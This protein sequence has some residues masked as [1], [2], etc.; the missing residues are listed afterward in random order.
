MYRSNASI[1]VP[2]GLPAPK[3]KKVVIYLYIYTQR[4]RER[5]LKQ[6]N[7]NHKMW[8][9]TIFFLGEGGLQQY[10]TCIERREKE[11]GTESTVQI[12]SSPGKKKIN[13]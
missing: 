13:Q 5:E 7:T 2:A 4:E 10:R 9:W 8:K 6:F 12:N 3:K 11:E 1:Y